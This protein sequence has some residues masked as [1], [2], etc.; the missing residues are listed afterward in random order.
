MTGSGVPHLYLLSFICVTPFSADGIVRLYLDYDP[1]LEQ[2]PLQFFSR[3]GAV[4]SRKR[5]RHG[6]ETILKHGFRRRLSYH[7]D[8]GCA[9]PRMSSPVIVTSSSYLL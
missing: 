5:S 4:A 2:I 9:G 7:R 3:D 1:T 8:V 6:L